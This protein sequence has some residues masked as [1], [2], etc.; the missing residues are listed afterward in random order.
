[1]NITNLTNLTNLDFLWLLVERK[2]YI[3]VW[4][5][6]FL[7]VRVEEAVVEE[8]TVFHRDAE[9]PL[10]DQAG[11]SGPGLDGNLVVIFGLVSFVRFLVVFEPAGFF[12][13]LV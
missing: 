1:M 6:V 5:I 11:N 7:V 2:V 4:H 8:R 10:W 9:E 3:A 12:Q 13:E